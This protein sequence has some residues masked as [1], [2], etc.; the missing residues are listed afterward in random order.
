MKIFC[1]KTGVAVL[2]TGVLCFASCAKPYDVFNKIALQNDEDFVDEGGIVNAKPPVITAQPRGAGYNPGTAPAPLTVTA[3]SS[4]GGTLSYQWYKNTADSYDDGEAIPDADAASYTPVIPESV[5]GDEINYYWVVVTNTND[6][7]TGRKT[8]EQ[9]SVVV[10]ITVTNQEIVDAQPP[11][12]TAQPA[13]AEYA[14]G[15]PIAA[16]TVTAESP[17]GGTLSYQWYKN[18]ADN[19]DGGEA[20][21]NATEVSYAPAGTTAGTAYYWVVVTNTNS[22]VTGNQY[23]TVSSE[24]VAITITAG[25]TETDRGFTWPVVLGDEIVTDFTALAGAGG[26]KASI[27]PSTTY[28]TMRGFGA[29]DAWTGNWVGQKWNS[30]VKEKIASWLFS[31]EIG[32]DGNPKGIGLSQWRVNLGAGSW[33]QGLNSSEQ[34]EANTRVKL[35]NMNFNANN[36]VGAW[37]RRAESFLSDITNP[38]AGYNWNKQAGQ[39]WFF[40]KAKDM[41]T[42]TLIAFSNSPL[43]CWT[44]SGTANNVAASATTYDNEGK[45]TKLGNGA[46]LKEDCYDDFAKYMADVAAHFSAEGYHFDYISPVNEPQWDW[47]EDKQEGT[48]WT[49]GEIIKIGTEL[50]AAIQANPQ[51]ANK[52][53]III[54][55]AAKWTY[56]YSSEGGRGEGGKGD[57]LYELFKASSGLDGLPAFTPKIFAGHTYYTHDTDANM[58]SIR[59]SV[60]NKVKESWATTNG[61]IEIFSSEWCLLTNGEGLTATSASAFDIALYLAKLAHCDITVAGAASWAYWTA[62][63]FEGGAKDRYALIGISPGT[64]AYNANSYQ[65]HTIMESGAAESFPTLW[66]LGAYSL[67]VRPGFQRIY[68]AGDDF[69]ANNGDSVTAANWTGLMGTAYKSPAGYQDTN[70]NPVNRIVAVWVNWG[71]TGQ[72]MAAEFTDGRKPRAIRIFKTDATNTGGNSYGA[73]MR[74]VEHDNGVFTVEGRSIYTV[75]YDF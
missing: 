38:A 63:D 61:G 55:E 51:I 4:D 48:P 9:K 30:D 19:Y 1:L 71:T 75:V 13:G 40:K 72:K 5:A 44:K 47:N 43:V 26:K 54:S 15:A 28:Q 52:T 42:E 45:Y 3:E 8:G 60:A 41:G 12:I 7:A 16:L 17:D 32:A 34:P 22:G 74:K 53:K 29:S 10:N 27:N 25:G 23:G 14:A 20:I 67:F 6:A 56:A 65:N 69:N 66:A 33:E 21:G 50:N 35:G 36:Q 59:T 68:L 73:G 46:N 58:K 39:Q 31:Q 2:L 57:Q 18:T 49:N 37:H 70:G 11:V 24:R 64:T 62:M